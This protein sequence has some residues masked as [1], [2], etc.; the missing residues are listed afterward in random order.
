M[1]DN[2]VA[3]FL[4]CSVGTGEV[5]MVQPAPRQLTLSDK[6]SFNHCRPARD[7][8]SCIVSIHTIYTN[9]YINQEANL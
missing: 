5:K 6:M 4:Y 1:K 9:K 3:L 8:S 2:C 7:R